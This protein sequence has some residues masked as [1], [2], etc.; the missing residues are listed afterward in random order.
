MQIESGY[1]IYDFKGQE[2]YKQSPIDKFKQL[3]WRP[4]PRT[5]LSASR[6]KQIVKNLRQYGRE[7][8]EIDQMEEMN[9]SSELQA[10]RKRLVS[11]WNAWRA[12]VTKA[13]EEERAESGKV[14][15]ALE[16][17]EQAETAV[18]EEWI[19]EVIEETEEVM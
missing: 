6:R 19:E 12:R 1:G 17:K 5:L 16:V 2:L 15:K 3:I 14:P 11:E 9:V 7:F 4:R 10:Q 18:L 8:D 13:L